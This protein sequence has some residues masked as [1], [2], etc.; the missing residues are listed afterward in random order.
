MLILNV[1]NNLI[2]NNNFLIINNQKKFIL[3]LKV[4]PCIK[5]YFKFIFNSDINMSKF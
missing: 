2:T 4:S 3:T 1:N 5:I